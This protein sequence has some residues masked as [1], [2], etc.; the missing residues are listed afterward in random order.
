MAEL[1][2]FFSAHIETLSSVSLSHQVERSGGSSADTMPATFVS[3]SGWSTQ[4]ARM[5]AA[6]MCSGLPF[7]APRDVVVVSLLAQA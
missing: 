7:R 3:V 5:Q 2:S 4:P 1:S 6:A